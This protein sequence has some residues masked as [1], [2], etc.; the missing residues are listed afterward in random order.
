[1]LEFDFELDIPLLTDEGIQM[2]NGF[3]S[4]EQLHSSSMFD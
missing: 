4:V 3:L 2:R 1:M